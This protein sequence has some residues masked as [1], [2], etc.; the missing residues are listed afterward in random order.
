MWEDQ[1]SPHTGGPRIICSPEENCH[2][3]HEGEQQLVRLLHKQGVAGHQ[4]HGG[5]LLYIAVETYCWE[6]GLVK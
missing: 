2:A 6:G 4:I 3:F 1:M 5:D